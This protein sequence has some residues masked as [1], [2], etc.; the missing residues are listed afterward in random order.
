[1][2][3]TYFINGAQIGP[4]RYIGVLLITE[5]FI[6][7]CYWFKS[8]KDID[9]SF[10]CYFDFRLSFVQRQTVEPSNDALQ[11]AASKSVTL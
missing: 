6:I 9:S 3:S 10:L 5:M 1:M 7:S 4:E 2:I 8:L 11:N